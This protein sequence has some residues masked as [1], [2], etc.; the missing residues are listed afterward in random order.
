MITQVNNDMLTNAPAKQE[1][2]NWV[3]EVAAKCK[4][5]TIHWVDGRQNTTDSA[6]TW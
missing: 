1:L 6:S 4:P 2:E 3:L 5:D